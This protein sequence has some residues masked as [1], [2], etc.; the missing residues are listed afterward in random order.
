MA[1]VEEFIIKL[2]DQFSRGIRDAERN[3]ESLRGTVGRLNSSFGGLAGTAVKAFAAFQ[4]GRA[5][6]SIVELGSNMEQTRV[7]FKTFL[8]D[9]ELANKTI[10]ELDQFAN[11]TP[12]SNDEVIKAGKSL[13]AFGTPVEQLK[14]DLRSIGDISSGTGKNFNELATIYGKARVAGTL[15]AED[16]NQ[17]TEA[18]IPVIQQFA[19]QMGVSESQVKKMASEG[20]VGFN[21]LQT[22]FQSMTGEGGMFFNLMDA[23]SK[24]FGGQVSTLK[25]Q[26]QSVGVSIG[27]ALLPVLTPLV[28]KVGEFTEWLSANRETVAKW[29]PII[30]SAIAIIGALVAIIKVWMFVQTAINF[31]LTA[32]PIGLIIMGIAALIGVIAVLIQDTETLSD[33]MRT[34]QNVLKVVFFPLYMLIQGIKILIKW[35]RQSY[36]TGGWVKTVVDA[37]AA[38]FD[39]LSNAI[40]G[41]VSWF[42]DLPNKAVAA[43]QVIKTKVMG[44]VDQVVGAFKILTNPFDEAGRNEGFAQLKKGAEA[45][46][47]DA[48]EIYSEALNKRRTEQAGFEAAYSTLRNAKKTDETLAGP[49]TPGVGGAGL[50]GA[51]GSMGGA[52]GG[53]GSGLS[54]TKS[55]APKTFNINID[56]LVKELTVST[57][58]LTESSSK[59]KEEITKAL[60]SAV[61]DLQVQAGQ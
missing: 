2:R 54:E 44:L 27:E 22:A 16:I 42:E 57:T 5:I 50:G 9:A 38:A 33:G 47:K 25:G 11:V 6:T 24:T 46:A 37:L 18:G 15:Y 55:S 26:L 34:F 56:S 32:N 61:N 39:W 28:K 41:A 29:V 58:N 45:Y 8:G 48:G 14:E 21:Q 36:E 23:Q 4:A 19:K 1:N 59:I 52:S 17:L 49:K 51:L 7:A 35:M 3:T 12:F 20:K 40:S 30:A 13:L 10:A 43:F 53:L 31:L 60:L